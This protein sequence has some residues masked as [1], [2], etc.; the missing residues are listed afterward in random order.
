MKALKHT[1]S[2]VKEDRP[3]NDQTQSEAKSLSEQ[4]LYAELNRFLER[5]SKFEGARL[6]LFLIHWKG[7]RFHCCRLSHLLFPPGERDVE[8]LIR[9]AGIEQGLAW[10]KESDNDNEDG[11]ET[12][13]AQD[14]YNPQL[15]KAREPEARD[16]ASLVVCRAYSNPLTDRK[17]LHEISLRISKLKDQ[18][19][20]GT[21]ASQAWDELQQLYRYRSECLAPGNKIKHHTPETTKAYQALSQ[22][23][24]RLLKKLPPEQAPLLGYIRRHL[25][26]GIEFGWK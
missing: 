7:H 18:I 23:L 6:L 1:P 21:N 14:T 9:Q 8:H 4:Q 25:S 20:S 2:P 10:K 19:E 26:T 17:T 24:R 16:L 12:Y 3:G 22:A 11:T 5:H 15:I 13:F